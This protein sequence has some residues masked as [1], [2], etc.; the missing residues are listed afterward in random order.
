MDMELLRETND[1]EI[2]D[3]SLD[4]LLHSTT[5]EEDEPGDA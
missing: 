5:E 1:Q 3:L 4:D 2:R